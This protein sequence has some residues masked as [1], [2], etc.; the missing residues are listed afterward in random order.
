M[1]VKI[2]VEWGIFIILFIDIWGLFIVKYVKV[3]FCFNIEVFFVWDFFVMI[4]VLVEV[5]IEVVQSVNWDLMCECMSD[6][7]EFF[8]M[9]S[10]FRR[11][12]RREKWGK[13]QN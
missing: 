11:L 10:L 6:L 9:I 3:V 2:V 1:M 13:Q 7:E 12:I 5:F 4:L 8:D